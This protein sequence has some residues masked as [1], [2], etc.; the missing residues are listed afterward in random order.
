[1]NQEKPENGFISTLTAVHSIKLNQSPCWQSFTADVLVL[2]ILH[3]TSQSGSE[4]CDHSVPT[5]L[6]WAQKIFINRK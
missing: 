2:L 3:G 1:M 5:V 4:N 6:Q